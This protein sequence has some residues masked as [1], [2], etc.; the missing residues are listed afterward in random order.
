MKIS[1][2]L[3]EMGLLKLIT[4]LRIREYVNNI[5]DKEIFLHDIIAAGKE[6]VKEDVKAAMTVFADSIL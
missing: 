1:K 4:I 2:Q 6:G 3:F 5:G